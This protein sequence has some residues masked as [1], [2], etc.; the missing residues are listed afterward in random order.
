MLNFSILF[1]LGENDVHPKIARRVDNLCLLPRLVPGVYALWYDGPTYSAT[2]QLSSDWSEGC[3]LGNGVSGQ[4]LTNCS[5]YGAFST[6]IG[7]PCAG[8]ST[9]RGI[10]L[11]VSLFEDN[12]RNPGM[13]RLFDALNRAQV[14]QAIDTWTSKGRSER[15]K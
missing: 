5:A 15:V 6:N 13:S 9:P 14:G 11:S 4:F 8:E 2:A 7:N 10:A 3:C 12:W 1:V